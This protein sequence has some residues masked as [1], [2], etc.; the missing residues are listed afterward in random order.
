MERANSGG[1]LGKLVAARG[2]DSLGKRLSSAVDKIEKEAGDTEPTRPGKTSWRAKR[3]EEATECTVPEEQTVGNKSGG[4]KDTCMDCYSAAE[5]GRLAIRRTRCD[6]T[7]ATT[8]LAQ[9]PIRLL[10]RPLT[11]SLTVHACL[12]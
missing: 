8:A 6:R 11:R 3:A 4:R 12:H 7:A 5:A 9:Q 10:T 2:G 1:T